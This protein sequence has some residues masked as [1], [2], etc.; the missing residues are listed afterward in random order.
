ML[1]TCPVMFSMFWGLLILKKFYKVLCRTH[2][3]KGQYERLCLKLLEPEPTTWQQFLDLCFSSLCFSLFF[4]FFLHKMKEKDVQCCV[5]PHKFWVMV[6]IDQYQGVHSINHPCLT[7]TSV[8][9][10][11]GVTPEIQQVDRIGIKWAAQECPSEKWG[12]EANLREDEDRISGKTGKAKIL[13]F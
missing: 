13:W 7:E 4:F 8:C 1:I 3:I 6:L 9:V 11:C 2:W 12:S 5:S 10:V